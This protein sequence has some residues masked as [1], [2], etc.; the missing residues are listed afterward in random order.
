MVRKFVH[1]VTGNVVEAVCFNGAMKEVVDFIGTDRKAIFNDGVFYVDVDFGR[2]RVSTI[3]KVGNYVA[4]SEDGNVWVFTPNV[5][6]AEYTLVNMKKE[7]D[8][9][10]FKKTYMP[11]AMV[12]AADRIKSLPYKVDKVLIDHLVNMLLQG[13]KA[14]ERVEQLERRIVEERIES[15]GR[16]NNNIVNLCTRILEGVDGNGHKVSG[17]GK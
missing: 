13:A 9:K 6:D 10:F 5:F 17:E 4:K 8:Y 16:G 11:S 7:D 15:R 1:K 2:E 3:V 14:T 12:D